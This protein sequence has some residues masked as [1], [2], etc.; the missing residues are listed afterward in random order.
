MNTEDK[1]DTTDTLHMVGTLNTRNAPNPTTTTNPPNTPNKADSSDLPQKPNATDD[2]CSRV[3]DSELKILKVL[4]KNGST[5][6]LSEIR[7]TLT[8]IT[9]WEGVMVKTLLYRL[10]DKGVVKSDKREVFYF[11]PLISEQD[12]SKYATS[13]FVSKIYDGSAKSLVASLIDCKQLND[14]DIQE[15]YDMFQ[16]V[17]KHE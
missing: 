4:W 16:V 11:T 5:M 6:K 13:A 15:L 10:V 1:K 12:Y 2:L 17:D 9:G 8:R 14:Q 3:S 7:K